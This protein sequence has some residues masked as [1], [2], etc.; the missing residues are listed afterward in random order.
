MSYNVPG[1]F[2]PFLPHGNNRLCCCRRWL[3]SWTRPL[4]PVQDPRAHLYRSCPP[5]ENRKN[6]PLLPLPPLCRPSHH[7]PLSSPPACRSPPPAG[8]SVGSPSRWPAQGRRCAVDLQGDAS[9]NTPCTRF[10]CYQQEHPAV[11]CKMINNHRKCCVFVR[12]H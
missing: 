10:S 4:G 2:C 5:E 7:L 9:K 11:F 3:V 12:K 1:R 6:S 8:S